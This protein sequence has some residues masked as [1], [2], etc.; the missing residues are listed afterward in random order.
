MGDDFAGN[1]RATSQDVATSPSAL[2]D[3]YKIDTSNQK[4]DYLSCV[5][6]AEWSH[7]H[8]DGSVENNN[9]GTILC[10]NNTTVHQVQAVRIIDSGTEINTTP[11]LEGYV[12]G[13]LKKVKPIKMRDASGRT[14]T[15]DTIAQFDYPE[16]KTRLW[17]YLVP[18][19]AN[20]LST[21]VLFEEHGI[22]SRIDP[23][24]PHLILEDGSRVSLEMIGKLPHLRTVG[25]NAVRVLEADSTTVNMN[26]K[27]EDSRIELDPELCIF[28]ISKSKEDLDSNDRQESEGCKCN[29]VNMVD[30]KTEGNKISEE[31]ARLHLP[32]DP[33]CEICQVAKKYLNPAKRR[34]VENQTPHRH[35][36]KYG[37]RISMDNVL[38][39]MESHKGDIGCTTVMDEYTSWTEAYPFRYYPNA[40]WSIQSFKRFTAGDPG[41][42]KYRSLR[43]DNGP[44]FK[45]SEFNDYLLD[46]GIQHQYGIPWKPQTEGRHESMHRTMN[47][48]TRALLLQAGLPTVMWNQAVQAWHWLKNRFHKNRREDKTPYEKR[49]NRTYQG[50]SWTFG[51]KAIYHQNSAYKFEVT[52]RVGIVL[53][54]SQGGFLILDLESIDPN[55]NYRKPRIMISGDATIYPSIFPAK[56][57]GLRG[58][59]N[60]WLRVNIN[61]DNPVIDMPT[62]DTERKPDEIDRD[63]FD[64]IEEDWSDLPPLTELTWEP[65]EQT[66]NDHETSNL[67]VARTVENTPIHHGGSRPRMHR[68]LKEIYDGNNNGYN[69]NDIPRLR[70]RDMVTTEDRTETGSNHDNNSDTAPRDDNTEPTV[71]PEAELRN[72]DEPATEAKCNA[73]KKLSLKEAIST[74]SGIKAIAEELMKHARYQTCEF[75]SPITMA[76]ARSIHQNA[77]F[78]RSAMLLCIKNYELGEDCQKTKARMVALGNRVMD[79]SGKLTMD[80]ADAWDKPVGLTTSRAIFA[81]GIMGKNNDIIV[82]DMDTAYLQAKYTGKNPLFLELDHKILNKREFRDILGIPESVTDMIRPVFRVIKSIYG[83]D[84]GAADLG[85]HVR[86]SIDDLEWEE[87]KDIEPNLFTHTNTIDD[88]H[89]GMTVYVD[90][91][92]IAGDRYLIRYKFGEMSENLDFKGEPESMGRYLGIRTREVATNDMN[93]RKIKRDLEEYTIYLVNTYRQLSGMKDPFKKRSTPMNSIAIEELTEDIFEKGNMGHH[94]AKLK[95][96]LL[97]IGRNTR[98]EITYAVHILT[99][100]GAE[101]WSKLAD[102]ILLNLIAYLDNTA[103]MGIHTVVC[104]R[105]KGL[106]RVKAYTDSDFGGCGLTGKST[107]GFYIFIEGPHGTK[108]PMEWGSKKQSSVAHSSAE[109]ELAAL[110]YA[111]NMSIIPVGMLAEKVF[112]QKMNTMVYID[113]NS[114]RQ[115]VS[116]GYSCKLRYASKTHNISIA[117]CHEI[118]ERPDYNLERVDTLDNIADLFT[119][120]L[121]KSSLTRHR[122]GAMVF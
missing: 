98:P 54:R 7:Y 109:A 87:D 67:E 75:N 28:T 110:C 68:L 51:C 37:D 57:M 49:F 27:T 97:W 12:E 3:K 21:T 80:E 70:P 112:N 16:L 59:D 61:H 46:K 81:L 72:D 95:G 47:A 15:L 88:E 5:V 77:R 90:D 60:T 73:V 1:N 6:F 115:S 25:G 69:H 92:A 64:D 36:E 50:P 8:K 101:N 11:S 22:R 96:M 65:E 86:E 17:K 76:E 107:S 29:G 78:V 31:H 41:D 108:I 79:V 56:E 122:T 52:G 55:N 19:G 23:D 120:P 119:K 71:A 18:G 102:K 2:Y 38:S 44:E 74:P 100:F 63:T 114:V 58:S 42:T 103:D 84:R 82:A 105:D 93:K 9:M 113:N 33:Q 116:N 89:I 66:T 40:Q 94:A 43:T 118:F 13:T 83:T 45:N 117:R 14:T 26:I 91:V 85:K 104:E 30:D 4:E 34:N 99:M 10:R 53:G 106:L 20:L 121:D 32:K 39:K 62:T 35:A 24:D 48:G 111:M